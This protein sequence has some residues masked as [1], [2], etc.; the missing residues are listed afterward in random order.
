LRS[1]YTQGKRKESNTKNIDEKYNSDRKL[2]GKYKQGKKED[3]STK[4]G[5]QKRFSLW[6]SSEL[7]L[8]FTTATVRQR[9]WRDWTARSAIVQ[10][11]YCLGLIVI[12]RYWIIV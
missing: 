11:Y 10:E 4:I 3:S 6:T 8:V 12:V 7:Q 1:K 9:Q 5:E 2:R